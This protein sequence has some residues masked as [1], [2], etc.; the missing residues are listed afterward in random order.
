MLG[1]RIVICSG[2]VK[3]ELV[4]ICSGVVKRELVVICSRVVRISNELLFLILF[5][6]RSRQAKVLEQRVKAGFYLDNI[7]IRHFWLYIYAACGSFVI[8]RLLLQMGTR[9]SIKNCIT[10]NLWHI[11]SNVH[12]WKA[13][14]P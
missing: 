7:W 6:F 4:V 13:G 9:V 3:R 1:D 10:M 8:L 2:V 11:L 12:I 14:G 5:Y